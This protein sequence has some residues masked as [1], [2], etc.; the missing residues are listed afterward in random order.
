MRIEQCAP[1]KDQ[2]KFGGGHWKMRSS[3]TLLAS[4]LP[5]NNVKS[6]RWSNEKC[7]LQLKS[8]VPQ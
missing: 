3:K 4:N 6:K 5:N 1:V 8:A 7:C 2:L